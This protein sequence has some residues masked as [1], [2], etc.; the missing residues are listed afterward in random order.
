M[1]A[2]TLFAF[3]DL[4]VFI[5]GSQSLLV[6]FVR[7]GLALSNA[8]SHFWLTVAGGIELILALLELAES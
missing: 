3:S 2:G 1:L 5:Q 7:L 6:Y 8:I 4:R